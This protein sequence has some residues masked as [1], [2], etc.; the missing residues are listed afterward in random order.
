MFIPLYQVDAFADHLFAGNPAAICPL[1]SWPD[2]GLLQS[3]AGENNLSETAFFVPA[4][5][6]FRLRWFTPKKEVILCGHATLASAWVLFEKLSWPGESI[7]FDTQSG[8]LLVTREKDGSLTLDLPAD[9]PKPVQE[10]PEGLRECLGVLPVEIRKGKTDYLYVLE[11]ESGVRDLRPDFD[12]MARLEMRGL[13]VTAPGDETDLVSRFFA[14]AVGINEDPV[15]GSAHALLVPYWARRL[16]KNSLGA[17][18]LSARGGSLQCELR[19]DR[20]RISGRCQL[21]LEGTIQ[22]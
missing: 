21:Y 7:P 2:D 22:V 15:T 18:Q 12:R 8:R 1:E 9:P 4:G 16:G 11:R 20:V 5:E 13:I 14:P 10:T 17:R 3:I 19:G 6:G